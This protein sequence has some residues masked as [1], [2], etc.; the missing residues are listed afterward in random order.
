[1]TITTDGPLTTSEALT[2]EAGE[3]AVFY[4]LSFER[5]TQ[6]LV[7]VKVN[8]KAVC[9]APVLWL[10]SWI[11]GSYLM[12]E[13]S[14]HVTAVNY[15]YG[16]QSEEIKSKEVKSGEIKNKQPSGLIHSSVIHSSRGIKLSKNQWQLPEVSAGDDVVLRYEVYCYDLSV[17]TAY[18]DQFRLYGNF[19]SL[20]LAVEGLE[21]NLCGCGLSIQM[22]LWKIRI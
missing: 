19:T 12:R 18:V 5:F 2:R 14:R 22:T 16:S 8:F 21:L 6:H 3:V 7:D 15:A 9:D 11:P 13:F 4:Q 20:A 1:M 10:P 17:R